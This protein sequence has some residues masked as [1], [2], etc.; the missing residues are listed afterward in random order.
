MSEDISRPPSPISRPDSPNFFPMGY[1]SPRP[2]DRLV[3][4]EGSEFANAFTL[5]G[6]LHP[7][8]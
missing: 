6:N 4:E 1:F 2:T 3:R 8:P 5:L 7:Q